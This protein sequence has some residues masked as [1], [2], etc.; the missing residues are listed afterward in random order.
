MLNE[1][2]TFSVSVLESVLALDSAVKSEPVPFDFFSSTTGILK[3]ESKFF[4]SEFAVVEAAALLAAAG[5]G[6]SVAGEDSV[7]F[8]RAG[9]CSWAGTTGTIAGRVGA[10]FSAGGGATVNFGASA[11]GLGAS[12]A[13]GATGV[14]TVA[15]S[16]G[17]GT[18][19]GGAGGC[20]ATATAIVGA[21]VV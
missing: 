12:G 13:G 18:T 3:T 21:V 20:V 7:K 14:S 5:G 19:T 11:T 4:G 1:G 17:R 10:G 16:G 8:V 6:D 9:L 15:V 2:P